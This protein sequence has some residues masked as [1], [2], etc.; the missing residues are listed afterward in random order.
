MP[1][2]GNTLGPRRYYRYTTDTGEVYK[3]L[4]DETLGTVVAGVLDDASPD[5]P[6]RFTPR[7]VLMQSAVGGVLYKKRVVCPLLTTPIYDADGS[8][9]VT[10]D[11][12]E[13]TTTGR[14]GEKRTFGSNPIAQT[15]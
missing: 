4:T 2:T 13:F 10:I 7:Y 14:V 12:Q 8:T 1:T 6:R 9:T 15:P 5:L 11:T 3:Y